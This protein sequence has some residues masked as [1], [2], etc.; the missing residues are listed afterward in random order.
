[1]VVPVL[2]LVDPTA[3][4]AS[5]V[6]AP[7]EAAAGVAMALL[8]LALALALDDAVPVQRVSPRTSPLREDRALAVPFQTDMRQSIAAAVS[9]QIGGVVPD[10]SQSPPAQWKFGGGRMPARAPPLSAGA[11]GRPGLRAPLAPP[12]NGLGLPW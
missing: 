11:V 4:V 6:V 1:M 8:P 10:P 5:R 9:Q 12:L 3:G 2:G 7:L